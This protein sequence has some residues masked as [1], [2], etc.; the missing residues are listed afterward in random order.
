MDPGGLSLD[1]RGL[2]Y[3]VMGRHGEA[4]NDFEDFL[5]WVDRRSKRVAAPVIETVGW[6]GFGGLHLFQDPSGWEG[7]LQR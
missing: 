7:G 1:S 2:V 3:A 5:L 6:L 4:I